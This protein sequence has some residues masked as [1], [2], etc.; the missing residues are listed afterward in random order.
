VPI[1]DTKTARV[2]ATILLFL[3]VGAFCWGARQTLIAFLFA[4]FFA[5]LL[6]PLVKLLMRTRV[7]R[8]HRGRSI[9]IVYLVLLGALALLFTL[10]GPRLAAEARS[11]AERLPTLLEGVTSGQIAHQI[12]NQRGWS[13]HT[14]LRAEQFLAGHSAAIL[15][16]ARDLGSR[17]AGL[18]TNAI[19]LILI[20]ILAI[21]F[22]RD[23]REFAE[24]I[25]QTADR[26][27][28]RQLLRG[29]IDDLH[30]MLAAYIRAQLILAAITIVAYTIVLT[31]LRAPYSYVLGVVGGMMEFVP[32]VGPFVAALSILGIAFL[33]NYQ[34]LLILAIFLGVWRLLQ[35][36]VNSP[37]IMGSQVELHPLAALFAVL[38]GAEIA[39]VVGVYLSVPIIA[40]LRILYR[41]WE[42]YESLQQQVIPPKDLRAA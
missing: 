42:T 6:D 35:D 3:A 28:Q 22:L 40:A 23:G 7:G 31:I 9:L 26:R 33:S 8:D 39:G 5:Y 19:W 36:Y 38:V 11:L 16:W 32:V 12:G 17:A 15:G 34:H 1:F 4:I 14:Q 21:F 2:L 20:P 24:S 25:I 27:A 41:R 30:Q 37:R 13:A 18:A 10:T 29:I